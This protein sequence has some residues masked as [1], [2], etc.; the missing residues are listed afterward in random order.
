MKHLILLAMFSAP[1][2][3]ANEVFSHG[4][5]SES[6]MQVNPWENDDVVGK[7][8]TSTI[9]SIKADQRAILAGKKITSFR[10]AAIA[11]GV[12]KS[13]CKKGNYNATAFENLLSFIEHKA[14]VME[15]RPA[16]DKAASP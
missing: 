16:L 7:V 14:L 6:Q 3:Q 12:L 9:E 2:A 5:D 1:F 11:A 4:G 10:N 8:W 13:E 15:I